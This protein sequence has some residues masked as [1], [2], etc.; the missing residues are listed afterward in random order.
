[1]TQLKPTLGFVQLL[2]YCV[3]VIVGAVT[4]AMI[5]RVGHCVSPRDLAMVAR[6]TRSPWACLGFIRFCLTNAG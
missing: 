6:A 3:G 1:M 4:L 5:W 2:F